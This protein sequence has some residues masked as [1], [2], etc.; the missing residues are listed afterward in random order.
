MPVTPLVQ[1]SPRELSL[2]IRGMRAV[3]QQTINH[4]PENEEAQALR[5]RLTAIHAQYR[6]NSDA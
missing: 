6:G 5:R 2:L 1:L 4:R 3:E